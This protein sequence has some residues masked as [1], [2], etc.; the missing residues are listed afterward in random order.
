[1]EAKSFPTDTALC[2]SK[3]YKKSPN[4]AKPTVLFWAC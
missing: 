4:I 2:L 3:L 1:M